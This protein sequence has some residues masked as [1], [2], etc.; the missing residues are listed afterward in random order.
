MAQK[1]PGQRQ[2]V[3]TSDVTFDAERKPL[4][5]ANDAHDRAETVIACS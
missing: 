2:W 3:P 5:T 4:S 1:F